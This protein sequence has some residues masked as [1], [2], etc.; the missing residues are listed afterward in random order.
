MRQRLRGQVVHV[1]QR[2]ARLVDVDQAGDELLLVAR[3]QQR[4]HR[5]ELVGRVVVLL[6]LA[7]LDGRAVVQPDRTHGAR[8]VVHLDLVVLL[9]EG[10]VVE[11]LLVR[12][13]PRVALGRLLVVVEGNAGADD[14]EHCRALVAGGRLEQ[15]A[16]LLGVAGER[17][18]HEAAVGSERLD[19][20]IDRGKLIEARI[21]ELLAHVGGGRELA[22]RQPVHAVVLDDIHHAHV[23]A[24][25]VLV[26]PE[27]DR[28][29]IAVAADRYRQQVAVDHSRSGDHRRHAPVHGVEAVRAVE[30]VG[31]RLAGAA[32]AAH[33]DNLVRRQRQLEGDVD[34]L[35]RYRVV[36]TPLAER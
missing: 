17:A 35:A 18:G 28:A 3:F 15:F 29:G 34:D 33:L 8:L 2:R 22:L 32:D 20:Q 26:L 31:G 25:Q 4:A 5:G 21:L 24:Q 10:D 13:A 19:T 23:A 30:E 16:H 11:L 1:G 27:A 6:Q 9:H 12:L 7:Q 14:V 36:P